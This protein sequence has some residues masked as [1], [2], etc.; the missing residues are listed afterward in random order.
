MNDVVILKAK[1][2]RRVFSSKPDLTR[3]ADYDVF[4]VNQKVSS[5]K[6][7]TKYSSGRPVI[8]DSAI[9]QC[10]KLEKYIKQFRAMNPKYDV[11][12]DLSKDE[13]VAFE[14]KNAVVETG[15]K[16]HKKVKLGTIFAWRF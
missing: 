11:V 12:Y 3:F 9:L 10:A 1:N 5:L 8:A 15:M 13:P 7:V 14:N 6:Y 4:S 2:K 16:N